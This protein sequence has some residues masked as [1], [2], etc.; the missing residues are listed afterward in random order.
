MDRQ[1][2]WGQCARVTAFLTGVPVSV[3]EGILAAGTDGMSVHT[4]SIWAAPT[5]RAGISHA[6]GSE[7]HPRAPCG[8]LWHLVVQ[9]IYLSSGA[10]RFCIFQRFI[11]MGRPACQAPA[12]AAAAAAA[13]CIVLCQASARPGE[14]H[15]AA[16]LSAV[17][18]TW[19]PPRIRRLP[20]AAPGSECRLLFRLTGRASAG[21]FSN[22]L[23][24]Q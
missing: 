12:W 16:V 18:L 21:S 22:G 9:Y 3:R 24:S 5:E 7:W 6:L 2:G 11:A 20:F 1:S 10:M 15:R 13:G 19:L 8:T 4:S 14:C 17:P 23:P